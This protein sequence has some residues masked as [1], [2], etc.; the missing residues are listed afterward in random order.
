MQNTSTSAELKFAI[1]LLESQ[2]LI[3]QEQLINQFKIT[4][5][6]LK[7]VNII[8]DSINDFFK[9]PLASDNLL[10]TVI[11]LASGFLTKKI[12]VGTSHNLFRN[13]LGSLIQVGV[14]SAVSNHSETIISIGQI[15]YQKLFHKNNSNTSG[16]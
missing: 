12:A 15:I 2:Q 6:C 4:Y 5:E 10:G 1:Q 14:T 3:K 9:P 11:G 8:K 16:L 7:P 13:I